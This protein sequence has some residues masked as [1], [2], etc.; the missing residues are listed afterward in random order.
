M[1]EV[2]REKHLKGRAERGADKHASE[3]GLGIEREKR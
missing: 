1:K 3:G 2:R